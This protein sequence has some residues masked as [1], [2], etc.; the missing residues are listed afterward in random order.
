MACVNMWVASE[1]WLGSVRPKA[2]ERVPFSRPWMNSF[3][4]SVYLSVSSYCR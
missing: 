1:P 4:C 2:K 3:F